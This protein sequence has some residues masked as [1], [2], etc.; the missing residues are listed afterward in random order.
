[1]VY[2]IYNLRPSSNKYSLVIHYPLLLWYQSWLLYGH[3]VSCCTYRHVFNLYNPGVSKEFFLEVFEFFET[4]G[5]PTFWYRPDFVLR[6]CVAFGVLW[7]LIALVVWRHQTRP[8]VLLFARCVPLLSGRSH[9]RFMT[10]WSS[11][12][13]LAWFFGRSVTQV[14]SSH[15]AA[16]H[17]KS[18]T[19]SWTT[20]L[21][22]A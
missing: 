17:H 14:I 7:M 15:P 22:A 2:I 16:L 8:Q 11:C 3:A 5:L 12:G 19:P 21:I 18:H 9:E 1:M 10:S 20:S 6:T 4:P 13:S